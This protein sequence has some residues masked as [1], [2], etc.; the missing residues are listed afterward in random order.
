MNSLAYIGQF[1]A[2]LGFPFLSISVTNESSGSSS[3]LLMG[4]LSCPSVIWRT[5]IGQ[6]T[7][8]FPFERHKHFRGE[9]VCKGIQSSI[10]HD[11][12]EIAQSRSHHP[13]RTLLER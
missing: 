10:L 13:E 1:F 3:G 8:L 7:R 11:Q 9:R 6:S 2:K 12:V 4:F 5:A